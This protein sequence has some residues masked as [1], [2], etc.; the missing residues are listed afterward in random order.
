[1]DSINRVVD[2]L[3][4][5]ASTPSPRDVVRQKAVVIHQKRMD[6]IRQAVQKGEIKT[7]K[8]MHDFDGGIKENYQKTEQSITDPV[9]RE[10]FRIA[11]FNY[12]NLYDQLYDSLSHFLP[13]E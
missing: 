9:L 4:V 6:A 10:E 13:E 7:Q 11:Y 8:E 5:V 1:V 2:S 3:A 12:W